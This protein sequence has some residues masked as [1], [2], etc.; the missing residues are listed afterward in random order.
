MADTPKN[1]YER[2]CV[3]NNGEF[4]VVG[5]EQARR[6][7]EAKVSCHAGNACTFLGKF[8]SAEHKNGGPTDVVRRQT[9][10]ADNVVRQRGNGRVL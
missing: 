4:G 10:P 2:V 3:D 5:Q 6:C 7:E 1:R 8:K 9:S